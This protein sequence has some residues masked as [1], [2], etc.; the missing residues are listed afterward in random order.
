MLKLIT[1][2]ARK[3]K[4]TARMLAIAPKDHSIPLQVFVVSHRASIDF[5]CLFTFFAIFSGLHKAKALLI[6][7]SA[8]SF[9]RNYAIRFIFD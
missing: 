6:T 7:Q 2:R 5:F 8:N 3:K 4:R 1:A 9:I